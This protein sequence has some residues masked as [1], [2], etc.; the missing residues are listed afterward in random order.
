MF[1]GHRVWGFL[2]ARV[3][4]NYPTLR[5]DYLKLFFLKS[6]YHTRIEWQIRF[7]LS[8]VYLAGIKD[9][10][11]LLFWTLAAV[12]AFVSFW[13]LVKLCAVFCCWCCSCSCC[14]RLFSFLVLFF[15]PQ[16]RVFCCDECHFLCPLCRVLYPSI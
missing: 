6:P 3:S 7:D 1:G 13:S 15:C 5:V 9:L 12:V 10:K 2:L 14:C 4:I 16:C 11:L 8:V